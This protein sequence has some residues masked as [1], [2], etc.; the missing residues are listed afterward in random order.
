MENKIKLFEDKKVRV[1]WNQDEEDWYFS[2]VDVIAV[3]NE[4]DYQTARKYWSVLK[5]RLKDEGFEPATNCSQLKMPA[6]DGKMRQTDFAN[7]ETILSIT[8][9]RRILRNL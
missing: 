2:V 6:T 4:S 3:L 9:V 8:K 1:A 7:T 5:V